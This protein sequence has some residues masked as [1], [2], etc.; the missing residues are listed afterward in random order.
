M[1]QGRPHAR[2]WAYLESL[3]PE[4]DY[5]WSPNRAIVQNGWKYIHAPKPELYDLANDP[6]ER[7]NRVAADPKR[8]DAMRTLLLDVCATDRRATPLAMDAAAIEQLRS[9]GYVAGGGAATGEGRYDAKDM[10]WALDALDEARLLMSRGRT[11]E[12]IALL[13]GVLDRDATNRYAQR[14]MPGC[15]GCN[16]PKPGSSPESRPTAWRCAQA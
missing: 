4:L 9:L 12:V 5:G 14:P 13:E 11:A 6:H 8:S 10:K 2:S 16:R 1:L 3:V 15:C 7:R